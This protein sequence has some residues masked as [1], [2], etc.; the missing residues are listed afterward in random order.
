MMT[1][2]RRTRRPSKPRVPAAGPRYRHPLSA[3]AMDAPYAPGVRMRFGPA[4]RGG[5]MSFRHLHMRGTA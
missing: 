4:A 1:E 3:A 5:A 2:G